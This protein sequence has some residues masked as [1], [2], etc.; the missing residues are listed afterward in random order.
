MKKIIKGLILITALLILGCIA[1]FF[2]LC[3]A[4]NLFEGI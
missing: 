4:I 3:L 2:G 1:A